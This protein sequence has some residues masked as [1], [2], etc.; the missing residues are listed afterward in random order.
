MLRP[1][2]ASLCAQ[3]RDTGSVVLTAKAGG[4]HSPVDRPLLCARTK[5]C[6]DRTTE[7]RTRV[8]NRQATPEARVHR[9][10]LLRT[11]QRAEYVCKHND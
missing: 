11:L 8:Y 9:S 10:G 6:P 1:A 2:A 5:D 7:E 4:W 3:A